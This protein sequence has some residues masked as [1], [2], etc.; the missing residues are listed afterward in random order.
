[1][2]FSGWRSTWAVCSS[3]TVSAAAA[4]RGRSR[5]SMDHGPAPRTAITRKLQEY[6]AGS[7][8]PLFNGSRAFGWW[9]TKYAYAIDPEHNRAAG[10]VP[11]PTRTRTPHTSWISPAHQFG[12]APMGTASPLPRCPPKMPRTVAAP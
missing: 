9:T 11:R 2:T 8:P 10:R 12:Q 6:I 3:D 1:Y 4:R 5:A 7:T